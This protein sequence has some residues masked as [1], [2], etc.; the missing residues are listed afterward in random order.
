SLRGHTNSVFAVVFSPD[1]KTLASGSADRT[2][3]LWDAAGG[4]ERANLK[5]H[6]G[7]ITSVCFSPD[8][9]TLASGSGFYGQP[10]EIKLWD[11]RTG[12]ERVIPQE[13]TSLVHS[14]AFS[15]DGKTLATAGASKR[16]YDP[17]GR[18]RGEIKLWD[19]RTGEERA[20]LK[21]HIAPVSSVVFSPDGKTL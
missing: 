9:K 1:G 17:V 20:V 15:P 19:A 16:W 5:G 3:T 6:T 10:G 18:L 21:E 12:Q 8:G 11:V 4:Q 2:I 14:V 7:F 13:R